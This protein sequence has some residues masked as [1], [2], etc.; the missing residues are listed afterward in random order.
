MNFGH[1][2]AIDTKWILQLVLTMTLFL[3]STVVHSV[4]HV[5]TQD[6]IF[7]SEHHKCKSLKNLAASSIETGPVAAIAPRLFTLVSYASY[8]SYPWYTSGSRGPP[9]T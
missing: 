9:K 5:V 3:G 1:L 6:E 8:M 7:E 2:K 4:M